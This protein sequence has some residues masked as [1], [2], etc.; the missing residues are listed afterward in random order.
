[1]ILAPSACQTGAVKMSYGGAWEALI[2]Q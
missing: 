2:E 1:M